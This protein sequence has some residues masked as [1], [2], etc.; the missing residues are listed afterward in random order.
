MA[1]DSLYEPLE[2]FK[3]FITTIVSAMVALGKKLSLG[4]PIGQI[5]AESAV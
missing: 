3:W 1:F 5:N 4:S 2:L